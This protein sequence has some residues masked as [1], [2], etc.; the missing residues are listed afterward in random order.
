MTALLHKKKVFSTAPEI[1]EPRAK[2]S[3]G[4]MKK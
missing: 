2:L 1:I 4:C 3:K